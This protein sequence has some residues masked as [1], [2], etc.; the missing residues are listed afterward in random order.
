VE[1]YGIRTNQEIAVLFY[2][3]QEF[4]GAAIIQAT[5]GD[6][7]GVHLHYYDDSE[8]VVLSE[9]ASAALGSIRFES[10]KPRLRRMIAERIRELNKLEEEG[11]SVDP[12][13]PPSDLGGELP[14]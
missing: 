12:P 9:A 7:V 5:A 1:K 10:D 3:D 4:L 8:L 13:P 2:R 11:E 6:Q 14:F